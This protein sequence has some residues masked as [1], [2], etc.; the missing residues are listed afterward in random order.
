VIY[1]DP[2]DLKTNCQYVARSTARPAI[3]DDFLMYPTLKEEMVQFDK[4][5]VKEHV[6]DFDD[7]LIWQTEPIVA[8]NY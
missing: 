3:A 1:Y 2:N 5:E 7:E 6:G 8:N 4:K